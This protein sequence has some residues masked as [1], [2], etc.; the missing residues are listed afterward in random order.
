MSLKSKRF[1]PP[2]RPLPLCSLFPPFH[3]HSTSAQFS[4]LSPVSPRGGCVSPPS[5]LNYARLSVVARRASANGEIWPERNAMFARWL[6]WKS[7]MKFHR[8]L[9]ARAPSGRLA[10]PSLIELFLQFRFVSGAYVFFLC[11]SLGTGRCIKDQISR[12]MCPLIING[13]Y[14]NRCKFSLK[15]LCPPESSACST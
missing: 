2:S 1:V 8:D 4:V 10:R 5:I 3:C 14:R 11:K 9:L 15:S 12:F 7:P 6:T 13:F